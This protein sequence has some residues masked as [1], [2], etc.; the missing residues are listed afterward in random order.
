V[1]ARVETHFDKLLRSGDGRK[2]DED[3]EMASAGADIFVDLGV[4]AIYLGLA[5]KG[6][7]GKPKRVGHGKMDVYLL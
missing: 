6:V 7:A 1:P 5:A 2:S 4:S 3:N